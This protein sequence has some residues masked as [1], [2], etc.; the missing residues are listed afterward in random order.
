MSATFTVTF[1]LLDK[2]TTA[3]TTTVT[4]SLPT[5]WTI[6]IA[7]LPSFENIYEIGIST[8][9]DDV[10]FASGTLTATYRQKCRHSQGTFALAV[11]PLDATLI[12]KSMVFPC[13]KVGSV[14]TLV[15]TTVAA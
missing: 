8:N 13:G 6:G 15:I 12:G 7:V 5:G 1:P 11:D 3:T 4:G 2:V 14:V 9:D 10:T